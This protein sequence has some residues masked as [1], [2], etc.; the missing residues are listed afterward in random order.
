MVITTSAC[1]TACAGQLVRGRAVRGELGGG[2]RGP[3][4]RIDR[5]RRPGAGCAPCRGPSSR[6]PAPPPGAVA[7]GPAAL[8]SSRPPV[9]GDRRG[10]GPPFHRAT[11]LPV[12]AP[13]AGLRRLTAIS[14]ASP[15][16]T[17]PAS[18]AARS[19][20]TPAVC[21][22]WLTVRA[23][24]GSSAAPMPAPICR[25]VLITPPTKPWSPS[26][27]PLV[28]VT[29]EPNAV[30]AVPKPTNVTAA[31]SGLY[32]PVAGNWV[33]TRKPSMATALV[34]TSSRCRPSRAASRA[35]AAPAAKPTMPCGAM[36]SPVSSG[37]SCS[38]CWKYSDSTSISPPFQTPTSMISAPPLRSERSR[39]RSPRTSGSGCLRS[40]TAN[41][42]RATAASRGGGQ[43]PGRGPAG[44][45]AFG[46]REHDAGHGHGDQH[47]AADI[48]PPPG[49]P[50]PAA[51]EQPR[52]EQHG[53]QPDRH[54]DQEHRPPAGELDQHAAEHLAG[55]EADRRGGAVQAQRPGARRPL[56]ESGGDQGQRGRARPAR[57]RRPA[58]PA[59]PP[60]AP[61]PGPARRPARRRRTRSARRR[62]SGG[63]RT[64]RRPGR[65]G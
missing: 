55:H 34:S 33:S 1:S 14:V 37:E 49:A 45:A 57:P 16:A 60:A 35:P 44:R 40:V 36:A 5:E 19:P 26:A 30:P 11:G 53:G 65:P 24:A 4:P 63:G 28:A 62:T 48:Q 52:G 56:R 10:C 64:D 15:A 61:G 47:G 51:A 39:S 2:F 13:R 59:P 6:C 20:L 58:P 12:S 8:N 18:M 50:F 3:V 31:S 21:P 46:H 32:P 17:A 29:I 9:R 54:V 41:P 22:P 43:H 27:T 7:G 25:L 42:A 38:T 23:I